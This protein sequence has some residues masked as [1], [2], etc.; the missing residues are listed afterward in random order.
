[1][2]LRRDGLDLGFG[3]GR[4][5]FAFLQCLLTDGIDGDQVLVALQVLFGQCQLRFLLI[6][7]GLEAVDARFVGLYLGLVDTRVDLGKQFAFSHRI[8]DIDV[9]LLNL[10]GYLGTHV[11]VLLCLQLTLRGNDL[12]YSSAGDGDGAKGVALG[13]LRRRVPKTAPGDE[14]RHNQEGNYLIALC[15]W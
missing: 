8:G 12:L 15:F 5:R 6:E 2:N 9:D 14:A 3:H 11:H 13:F 7:L 1:M 4:L 10:P